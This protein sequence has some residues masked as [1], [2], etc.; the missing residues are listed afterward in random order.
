MNKK[1]FNSG[2]GNADKIG[3][4]PVGRADQFT[5]IEE[6]GD[7]TTEVELKAVPTN[8]GE[9]HYITDMIVS[10]EAAMAFELRDGVAAGSP[11]ETTVILP[12]Q[13]S[14]ATT[15]HKYHFAMPIKV[16]E[17]KGIGLR[18]YSAGNITIVINGY[19]I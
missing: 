4:A 3:V 11:A 8:T 9:S 12:K 13:Y 14:G 2:D 10:T 19:T 16:G 1:E 7:A 18:S 15:V 5:V 17:G 6:T